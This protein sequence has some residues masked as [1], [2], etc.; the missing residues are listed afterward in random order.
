MVYDYINNL[1]YPFYTLLAASPRGFAIAGADSLFRWA[2][3]FIRNDHSVVVYNS[4]IKSPVAV[5]YLWSSELGEVD[6]YNKNDLPVAPFRTD[7]FK[8][9]TSGKNFSNIEIKHKAVHWWR[10]SYLILL[11]NNLSQFILLNKRIISNQ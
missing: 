10:S 1:D 5:R 7:N 8:G 2:K 3:A 6:L 9:I 4:T 11:L